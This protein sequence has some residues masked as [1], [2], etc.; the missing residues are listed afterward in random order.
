MTNMIP[1]TSIGDSGDTMALLEQSDSAINLNTNAVPWGGMMDRLYW[2][3]GSTARA[4]LQEIVLKTFT[5]DERNWAS[6]Y[7]H[8]L[9]FG[10]ETSLKTFGFPIVQRTPSGGDAKPIN[11]I[12]DINRPSA[13]CM[14]G[15]NP[16]SNSGQGSIG[17]GSGTS[18]MFWYVITT[19]IFYLTV[20]YSTNL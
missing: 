17:R 16:T 13:Q 18:G 1:S 3:V 5:P 8:E 2:I 19:F 14:A 4:S 6:T 7:V 12:P 20:R 10:R 15:Y 9:I 11:F